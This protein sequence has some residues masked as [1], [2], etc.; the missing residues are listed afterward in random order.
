MGSKTMKVLDV[1]VERVHF[2][3]IMD[4][5]TNRNPYKVYNVWYNGGYHRRKLAEYGNFVSVIEFLRQYA[6]NAHWGFAESIDDWG[7]QDAV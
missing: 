7:K 4:K 1:C 3:C 6:H 2:V 5:Q